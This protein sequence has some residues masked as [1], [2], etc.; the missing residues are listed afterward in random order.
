MAKVQLDLGRKALVEA[1]VAKYPAYF[2]E[3][4]PERIVYLSS[5]AKM[6]KKPVSLSPVKSPYHLIVRHKF[7]ITFYE[8]KLEDL[9]TAKINLYLLRELMRISDFE[10]GTLMTFP[11]QDFPEI[12]AKFGVDWEDR[13]DIPD[14]LTME[15]DEEDKKEEAQP[16]QEE[17]VPP[18]EVA[19]EV[20]TEAEEA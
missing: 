1:V 10:D 7:I 20:A 18:P 4:D 5:A 13:D 3:V 6:A 2:E 12:L 17:A 14:V 11:V 8:K 9:D 15:E 19:T 16:T